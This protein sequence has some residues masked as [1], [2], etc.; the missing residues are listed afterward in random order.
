MKHKIFILATFLSISGCHTS[1][2]SLKNNNQRQA[3]PGIIITALPDPG[4][5][6]IFPSTSF[7]FSSL[8]SKPSFPKSS[9]IQSSSSSISSSISLSTPMVEPDYFYCPKY[10]PF[11]LGSDDFTATFNYSFNSIESQD[12]IERIR[13]LNSSQAV[14]S[15]SS[16]PK[17]YYTKGTTNSVGF[18]IPLHDYWNSGGL[19]LKFEIV[20]ADTRVVI[21]EYSATFYPPSNSSVTAQSLKREVYTSRSLGFYGDGYG[22][23]S[24]NE[25]I[26][27]THFG[28]YLDVDYYYKLDVT[29][30]KFGY[31][32][33]YSPTASSLTLKFNDAENLF[34]YWS[35]DDVDDVSFPLT[36]N[37]NNGSINF[38]LNTSFYVNKRTLQISQ[39]Y[40]QGFTLTNDFYLPINGK[41]KFNGKTLYLYINDFGMDHISTVYPLRYDIDKNLIGTCS[42]GEYCIEG[43]SY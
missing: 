6:L 15:A 22:L 31:P 25:V 10:G 24:L 33:D 20:N 2:S 43:G 30:N 13:L 4:D 23:K 3:K 32:N 37:I 36:M 35:H 12:I 16:K 28:D 42:D 14:V 17:I 34:P 27:F 26:D 5:S 8:T 9:S 41:S 40:R 11:P 19:T 21:K 7:N 38:K 39:T 29:K 18:L 1:L